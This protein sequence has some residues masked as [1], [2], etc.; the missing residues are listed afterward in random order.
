[1]K[2]L[3]IILAVFAAV[4]SCSKEKENIEPAPTGLTSMTFKAV[5][6]I[7]KTSLAS[8]GKGIVW[9]TTDKINV[10]SGSAFGT[11][12][13]FSVSSVESE[14]KTAIFEGLAEVSSEY[15]ALFPYQ[16]E[17]TITS[18]GE[19]SADIP[20]EQNAVA[21]SFGPEA[22][23]SVAHIS[24]SEDVA[25][26]NVGALL[27][28][29]IEATDV[30]GLMVETLGGGSLSGA[31]TIDYNN[32]EPA[33]SL[34]SGF[35]YVHTA[36]SGAG[37]YY[38][39][40]LPGTFEGGVKITLT[41][42]GCSASV[43]NASTLVLG[44]NDNVHL[45][46]VPASIPWKLDSVPETLAIAG[47]AASEAGQAFRKLDDG[48]FSIVTRVQAG[49]IYF[50]SGS[51]RYY[52]N[53]TGAI[54]AGEGSSQ[55]SNV[56]TSGLA[57]ITVNFNTSE[58]K[59]EELDTK[60]YAQWAATNATFVTLEY[61]GNGVY[62]GSGEVSFYGPGRPGTPSWCSWVEERYS[63]VTYVDGGLIRWG[64]RVD[65]PNGATL[66]DGSDD[67]YDIHEVAK[68]D[69]GNLWKMDHAFDLKAVK[70]TINTNLN[71]KFTHSI[72]ETEITPDP[73]TLPETLTLNGSGAE[74]DGQAFQKISNGQ[75]RIYAKITAAPVSFKS[76]SDNYYWNGETIVKGEG[77]CT[78]SATPEGADVTRLTVDIK[79][80]LILAEVVNKVRALYAADFNDIVTLVYQ[81]N[82][83]WSGTGGVWYR[84]MGG[85]FDERYYF[86]PT[87]D[88]DQR[89]CW[90]RKD[91]VDPENRP[92]GGQS[93]DYFDC[94]EFGWSQ[95]EHC[96]KL[97]TA[98]NNG[99]STTITLYS[100]KDGVM[101]HTV[102]VN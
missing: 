73:G 86:I 27:S 46:T 34:V 37:T 16:A 100:N 76:G 102:V 44:R 26:K 50:T 87:V 72:E 45:F 60:V 20:A 9:S 29:S 31:V 8:D 18:D 71:G 36:V 79:N 22:N 53:S 48:V 57:R 93:A 17:A 2:K 11:N 40:V 49:N 14:G 89:L 1:M 101:T 91:G 51:E 92:D 65:D 77:T 54:V 10:F 13:Q 80:G 30:T 59:V 69:W 99:A 62:I 78:L 3:F 83:V 75:F 94:A 19:I 4:V 61:E 90:G 68:T 12:T 5:G 24:G 96:W 84:D 70:I 55:L 64:S 63:F 85:W 56:P 66:P 67:Y 38:F 33:A 7:T 52:L 98:A 95:W 32:G 81:G 6:E 58:V 82:G 41:K 42:S 74:V 97:P 39:S 21:G 47:T 28:I 25:F 35:N 15:Y 23:L 88:G 43:S